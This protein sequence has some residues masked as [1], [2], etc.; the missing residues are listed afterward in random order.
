MSA[1]RT[2]GATGI[3]VTPIGLGTW[4]LSGARGFHGLFWKDVPQAEVDALVR[5]AL[6]GGIDWFDTAE[7][8]GSGKSE[9]S[10]AAALKA[11]GRQDAKIATKWWPLLRT[12][13]SIRS[14]ID[15]RLRTL[16]G[17]HHL[18][19]FTSRSRSRASR[20]RW[21]PWPTW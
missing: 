12:A 8:Y 15:R 1:K 13:R 19:R 5:A 10:L 3:E 7:I 20:A 21:T 18:T 16:G 2:L 4:Q 17:F 6:D 9:E 14:T 11:S